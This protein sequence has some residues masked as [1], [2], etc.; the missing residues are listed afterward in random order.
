MLGGIHGDNET[1]V[2]KELCQA[3]DEWIGIHEEDGALLPE[4]TAQREYSGKFVVRVGKELHQELAIDALREGQS[5]NSYCMRL[6]R[7][8]RARYGD[9]KKG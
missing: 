7:E 4:P 9:K 6:L 1:K 8:R 5:L 3:V 2:Y